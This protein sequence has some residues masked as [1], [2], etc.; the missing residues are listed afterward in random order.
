MIC[1]KLLFLHHIFTIGLVPDIIKLKYYHWS[2][3]LA[4]A[5]HAV[6]LVY[7]PLPIFEI[8]YTIAMVII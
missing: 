5:V 2:H 8:S 6:L 1:E 3:V 4:P 7:E